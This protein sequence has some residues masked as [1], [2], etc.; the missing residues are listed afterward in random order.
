MSVLWTSELGDVARL[1]WAGLDWLEAGL[2]W[3][4]WEVWV[5]GY[6]CGMWGVGCGVWDVGCG[7]WG[8]G[9]GVWDVG[10]GMWYVVF[11]FYV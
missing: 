1:G 3:E 2:H 5:C 8:V 4:N 6:G 9:C 10:C 11:F 7:M